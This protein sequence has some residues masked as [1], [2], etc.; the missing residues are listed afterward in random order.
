MLF[1][2]KLVKIYFYQESDQKERWELFMKTRKLMAMAM[3]G[4][5]ALPTCTAFAD[6]AEFTSDGTA[7]TAKVIGGGYEI[8]AELAEN[9]THNLILTLSGTG[10]LTVVPKKLTITVNDVSRIYG[11][12]NPEL[13]VYSVSGIIS[14]PSMTVMS[15]GSMSFPL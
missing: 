12:P 4:A 3:A 14:S 11:E 7:K 1:G 15:A 8:T 6:S 13:T 9:K 5:M 10:I 2:K